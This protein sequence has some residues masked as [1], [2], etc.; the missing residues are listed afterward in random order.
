[1][2]ALR[3]ESNKSGKRYAIVAVPGGTFTVYAE[4][5]NHAAHCRGGIATSWRYCDKGLT[6]D[7][8]DALF[9]R[10]IAGKQR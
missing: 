6:R 4:C 5:K 2:K 10:K 7:A 9:A 8:A 3:M 1:M